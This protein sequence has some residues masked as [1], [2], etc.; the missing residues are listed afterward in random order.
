MY[1]EYSPCQLLAPYIDNYWE[2]KGDVS[3]GTY[4][5]IL[6]DGCTDFIFT[7]GEVANVHDC[8]LVM[9]PYRSYFVGSMTKYARL[10]T[11]SDTIHM[12]G[13]RFLPCGVSCFAQLPLS[14]FTDSRIQTS[15]LN[16]LF[17]DSIT[18]RLCEKNSVR[19]R[20]DFI[21]K[22]LLH[23]LYE[24]RYEVDKRI[25]YA[26]AQIDR[27]Q[28]KQSVRTLADE[29][30][31]SQRHFERKF[32]WHTGVS[33][34]KY[35]RIKQFQNAVELLRNSDFEGLLSVA[36]NSGYYDVP[37]LSREIKRLSGNTPISFLSAPEPKEITLTYVYT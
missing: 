25:L 8:P 29:T 19:E 10:I 21:E 36:I 15:D 5:N 11:H 13:I 9:Q 16:T 12:F 4:I 26:V 31:L 27:Y 3:K 23:H 18:D 14:E 2:F 30:N 35:S 17:N 7:L 33:P 1:N 32:K 6:P 20:I 34:K 24:N 22:Y 37:H 28:G